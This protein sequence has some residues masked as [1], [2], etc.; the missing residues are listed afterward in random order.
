MTHKKSNNRFYPI[1]GFP[2]YYINKTTSDVL[3]TNEPLPVILDQTQNS[4]GKD[5]Y[6]LVT[7]S[8]NKSHFIHRLM[9]QTFLPG[10]VKAHVNHIDGNKQNNKITNLEWATPQENSQH[11]Y[12]TGLSTID[13]TYKEVHQ[14]TLSGKYIATFRSAVF[15]EEALGIAKTNIGKC[16]LGKRPRAGGYL[17]RPIKLDNVAPYTGAPV[18]KVIRLTQ[19]SST[20]YTDIHPTGQDFYTEV[21][22]TTGIKK[23]RIV[24]QFLKQKS[25][26]IYVDNYKFERIYFE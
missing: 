4:L 9:A 7:L 11:A 16:A 23:H 2:G 12:D 8:D 1:Q 15:A 26:V 21:V 24:Q 22:A 13:H 6:Y 5:N 25:D 14:Y 17:W 10:P 18:L 20:T 3:C 19:G